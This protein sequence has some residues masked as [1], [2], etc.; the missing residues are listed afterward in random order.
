MIILG[1]IELFWHCT[2]G[3]DHHNTKQNCMGGAG[4]ARAIYKLDGNGEEKM[5]IVY[6]WYINM[7]AGILRTD[8]N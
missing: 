7:H 8:L 6:A 5:D 4:V 1:Y 3:A 2:A